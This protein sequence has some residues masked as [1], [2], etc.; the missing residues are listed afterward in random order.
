MLPR[1]HIVTDDAV[2]S[3]RHFVQRARA[4]LEAGGPRIA[5]HVRGHDTPTARLFRCAEAAHAAGSRTG[6]LVVVN[7]RVDVALACGAS[8]LQLGRGSLPVPDARMLFTAGAIGY[9]AHG[10]DEAASAVAAGADFVLF[11][12]VWPTATHPDARAAGMQGLEA[13]VRATTAPTIGIGGVTPARV[14]E[15]AAGGA[16]GVAVLSGVWNAADAADATV[17]YLHAL[18][19]AY[20]RGREKE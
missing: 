9:S 3:D 2:L 15:A 7:D 13:A 1:L 18:D 16:W 12:S 5:L 11:G 19:A 10:A 6:A 8:G 4:V 14:Q 17:S 20:P